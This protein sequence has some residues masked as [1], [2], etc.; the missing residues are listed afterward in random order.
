MRKKK[1]LIQ[2]MGKLRDMNETSKPSTYITLF[3]NLSA[4]CNVQIILLILK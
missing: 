3:Q 4:L 1:K 2:V